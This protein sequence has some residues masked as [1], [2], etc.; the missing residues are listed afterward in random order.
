ML[1]A[2]VIAVAL[3]GIGDGALR[4]AI[5]RL[6]TG[7]DARKALLWARAGFAL[8]VI[9]VGLMTAAVYVVG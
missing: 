4:P 6:P 2:I 8:T 1:G 9:A 3:L 7:G 5:K